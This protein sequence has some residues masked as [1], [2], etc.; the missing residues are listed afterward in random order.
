MSKRRVR[1]TS[2]PEAPAVPESVPRLGPVVCTVPIDGQEEVVDLSDLGIPRL[3]R[4]MAVAL[5]EIAR[6]KGL[7]RDRAEF[8][9]HL[10]FVRTFLAFTAAAMPEHGDELDL[11]D[12]EADLLDAFEDRQIEAYGEGSQAPHTMMLALTRMLR[13]VSKAHPD[14]FSLDFQSR[15]AYA[16]GEKAPDKKPLDAYPVPVFDAFEAAALIEVG[17]IRDRLLEGE[18]LALAGKD[19]DHHGWDRLENVLWW[20]WHNGPISPEHGRSRELA[21]HG[22]MRAVNERLFLSVADLA[23]F[24]VLLGCQTGMEPEAVKDLRPGCLVN[25][26][27][28]FVSVNYLKRRA[29]NDPH[30]T[31][32]VRDGGNLRSPGGLIRLLMRLTQHARELSGLDELWIISF[33]SN[34]AL[35]GAFRERLAPDTAHRRRFMATHGIDVMKDRDGSPVKLDLRR[36]RKTYKSKQYLRAGGILPDFAS[37]HTPQVAGSHY[38]DIGAHEEIHDQAIEAGLSQALAVALPP[39]VVLNDDGERLDDGDAAIAP[40]A[41]HDALSG[42]TDVWLSACQDFFASPFAV[43]KGAPCPVPPWVCLECPNAV[44]T[45]RHLPAV[46]SA[47][48]TIERQREEFSIAEWKARFGLAHERIVTGVLA[49]FSTPQITTARAIAEADGA[50]LALPTAL[51][52]TI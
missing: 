38:A 1:F 18:R 16:S 45:T 43:K 9:R 34:G 24:Q 32:R 7:L 2:A 46:L 48:G 21:R 26:A 31:L 40:E 15:I 42:A 5:L 12:L 23:P 35:A 19:P 4:P 17:K 28:G 20:V 8:R 37:G 10:K 14:R 33:R 11:D 6:P 52:E 25:P 29:H 39:P 36:L 3:A 49:R 50:R 27:R 47:L 13:L 44:F 22:R 41:V 30:K 51:L